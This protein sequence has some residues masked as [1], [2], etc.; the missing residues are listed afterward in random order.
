MALTVKSLQSQAC[1]P[2]PA[3]KR[4]AADAS[5]SGNFAWFQ[6][7]SI[8]S[9]TNLTSVIRVTFLQIRFNKLATAIFAA[10]VLSVPTMPIFL[11]LF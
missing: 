9:Q 5:Q 11:D 4:T 6:T 2:D 1:L 10:I 8:H 7:R 3:I